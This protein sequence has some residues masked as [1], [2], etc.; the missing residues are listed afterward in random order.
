MWAARQRPGTA[1]VAG[2]HHIEITHNIVH[3]SVGNGIS[4]SKSEFIL[5]EGNT[6]FGNASN[7]AR[8]GISVFHAE[9]VSGDTTTAGYRTIVRGNVSYGNVTKTG[10][11]TDGN[12]IIIDSFS[13]PKENYGAY[14]YPTL[15]E[16]N[17]VYENG[18]KGVQLAWS[19]NVTVRNNTAWHNSLDQLATGTWKSEI[20]NMNSSHNTF[21][22]NIA[23]SD[24]SKSGHTALGNFS[25]KNQTNADIKYANNLT[26]NGVAGDQALHATTGNSKALAAAGNLL[27]VL[28][29]FV[30]AKG[31]DFRIVAGSA[32][33]DAGTTSYNGATQTDLLGAV[34]VG[35][36][37]LGAYEAAHVVTLNDSLMGSSWQRHPPRLRGR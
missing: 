10:A 1:T 5:I 21:V 7:G 15:V 13:D 32:A 25:N 8:S 2:V 28:P 3:D 18:G 24:L 37:D 17:V 36:I 27:G 16:N 26:Y 31:H 29:G 35:A 12:G 33:I 22:N 6:T 30:D 14:T 19:D 23:V 11:H 20:S 34:R 9:N 4:A